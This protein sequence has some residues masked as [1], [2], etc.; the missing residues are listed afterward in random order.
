M[1]MVIMTNEIQAYAYTDREV[2]LEGAA[3][4][5]FR[6]TFNL[7]LAPLMWILSSLSFFVPSARSPAGLSDINESFLV[8]LGFA[9]SI[10]FPI[11]VGC[12]AYGIIQALRVNRTRDI[13]RKIGGWTAAGFGLICVWSLFSAFAPTAYAQW[14]TAIIFI[15]AM[16]CLVKAM[17][18]AS[19]HQS[20][21][22]NL[23]KILVFIPLSLI[24]GWTSLAVFL[25][26]AP[27]IAGL[28]SGM[29]SALIVSAVMLGLALS[30]AAFIIHKS[31]ANRAYAFPII[32]GLTFLAVKQLVTE[33]QAPIIGILAII[34][35]LIL[36]GI[37][38]F[39]PK[40]DLSSFTEV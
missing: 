15:P 4:D 7:V 37:T 35:V 36:I 30:W 23:E 18:I 5:Y 14:G 10:W 12:I 21:F 27:N 28:V 11:F 31:G 1:R 16:L 33:Q 22:D 25:N 2:S 9:F 24:A 6:Q 3:R 32:W 26:W 34:G 39:K 29:F 38:V 17:L 20:A 19:R 8:P 13:F 40:T